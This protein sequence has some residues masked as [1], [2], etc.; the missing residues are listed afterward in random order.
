MLTAKEMEMEVAGGCERKAA[1]K[2][3]PGL[4][5]FRMRCKSLLLVMV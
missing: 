1:K 5:G 4:P 2:K 3:A